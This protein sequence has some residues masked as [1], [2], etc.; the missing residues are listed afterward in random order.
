M[1]NLLHLDADE[2][3][4][5][6]WRVRFNTLWSIEKPACGLLYKDSRIISLGKSK[7]KACVSFERIVHRSTNR[8]VR[9]ERKIA[10][11]QEILGWYSGI[12]ALRLV[13]C[14]TSFTNCQTLIYA[15]N[16]LKDLPWFCYII[17]WLFE[18]TFSKFSTVMVKKKYVKICF[19][20]CNLTYQSAICLTDII[21]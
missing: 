12:I 5:S 7:E 9:P 3:A 6:D 8:F 16:E 20:F 10:L 15:S 19:C 14:S 13:N 11:E 21:E 18:V 17:L 2:K 4:P 1:E